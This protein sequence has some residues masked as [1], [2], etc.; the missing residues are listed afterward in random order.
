MAEVISEEE[1]MVEE[2][3]MDLAEEAPEEE[4]MAEDEA[5]EAWE[6]WDQRQVQEAAL[7]TND[8]IK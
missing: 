7:V 6:A 8:S 5:E 1:E 3:V 4:G 2:E